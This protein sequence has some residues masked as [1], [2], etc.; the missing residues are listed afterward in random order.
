VK[1]PQIDTVAEYRAIQPEVDEAIRRVLESGH[2]ILGPNVAALE[3]EVADYVGVRYGV[4]VASGTDALVLALRALE[5]GPGDEVIVPAF[6]F[7]A[8]AEAV[9]LVGAVPVFVD[10][11]RSTGC[12]DTRQLSARVTTRTRGVVPV[13]LYGHPA[14]MEDVLNIARERSLRVIEDNAQALG[15]ELDG[16]KTGSFGDVGCL[17]F[18]PSKNLGACGDGGMVVTNDAQVAERVRMLRTHGWK[19]KYRPTM[20]GYNSRLDELQA[21]ILRVKL[22]HLDRRNARRRELADAYREAL[23]H[24]PVEVPGEAPGARHVYHVYVL[25]VPARDKVQAELQAAGIGTSTYYPLPLHLVEPCRQY[26]A[27]EGSL[28]IAE[29]ACAETLA[30]PLFPE[31]TAEQVGQ[32]A[33]AIE[34]AVDVAAAG[35]STAGSA[36]ERIQ[37]ARPGED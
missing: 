18:F 35:F 22:R 5:I 2:F 26:G 14:A 29:A 32:V 31:M 36:R 16:R 9:L 19:E 13:H 30:I 28:P 12:L 15:A 10:V 23:A 6:T 7:F 21:A 3:R 4:G 17:S 25:R 11:D 33:S 1:I 37:T 24:L 8:T 27:G 34:R 20:V